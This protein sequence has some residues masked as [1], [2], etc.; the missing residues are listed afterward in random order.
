MDIEG[1]TVEICSQLAMCTGREH[2]G[3]RYMTKLLS[4]RLKLSWYDSQYG[5]DQIPAHE[6]TDWGL[7]AQTIFALHVKSRDAAVPGGW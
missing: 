5:K 3:S 2:R 6:S 7:S 1:K 4:R